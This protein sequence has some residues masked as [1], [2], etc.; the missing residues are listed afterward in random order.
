MNEAILYL[1]AHVLG[2][3]LVFALLI[4]AAFIEARRRG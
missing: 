3:T 4:V 2:V 1:L